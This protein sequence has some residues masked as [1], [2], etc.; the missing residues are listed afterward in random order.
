MIEF[1]MEKPTLLAN[2]GIIVYMLMVT[3]VIVEI[4]DVLKLTSAVL[5]LKKN[6]PF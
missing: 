4:K 5:H 2:G 1:I 6:G 3:I